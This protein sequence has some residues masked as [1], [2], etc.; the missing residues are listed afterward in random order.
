MNLIHLALINRSHEFLQRINKGRLCL[1]TLFYKYSFLIIK[2][3]KIFY[4][5]T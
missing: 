5:Q 3:K 4:D 2:I 1:P